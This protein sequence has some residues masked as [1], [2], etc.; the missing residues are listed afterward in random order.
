MK[1]SL[2]YRCHCRAKPCRTLRDIQS[3]PLEE[4]R[5]RLID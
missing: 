2:S 3:P 1:G 5:P 4:G